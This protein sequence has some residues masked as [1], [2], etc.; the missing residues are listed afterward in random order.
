ME[1]IRTAYENTR[2]TQQFGEKAVICLSGGA[3]LLYQFKELL[4]VQDGVE[5]PSRGFV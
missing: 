3:K 4:V 5:C 2:A 1:C